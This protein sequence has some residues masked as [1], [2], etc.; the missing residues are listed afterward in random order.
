MPPSLSPQEVRRI[1]MLARLDLTDAEV[2]LFAGQLTA[3]LGY[4]AQ[5][6]AVDTA[7]VEP[8]GA[9]LPPLEQ[10]ALRA[11]TPAP[12]LDRERLL[13]DAPGAEPEAGFF[14]VPRVLGS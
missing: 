12:S 9:M 3:I 13:R 4:A 5:L 10:T 8:G 6:Q 7:G 14:T 2:D 11:D 1:A